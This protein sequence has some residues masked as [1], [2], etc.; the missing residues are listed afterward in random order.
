M[1][2]NDG[3]SHEAA[4]ESDRHLRQPLRACR[5]AAVAAR[6]FVEAVGTEAEAVFN[7]EL[8]QPFHRKQE[9]VGFANV[10]GGGCGH[11]ACGEGD[12]LCC[13]AESRQAECGG[14]QDGQR[15]YGASGVHGV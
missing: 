7:A 13:R 4:L 6:L 9:R 12:G 10:R 8:Q 14:Q 1:L 3:L 2:E 15:P 5:A 11:P